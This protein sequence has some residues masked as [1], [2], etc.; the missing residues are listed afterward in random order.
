[1]ALKASGPMGKDWGCT[2]DE[3]DEG[4]TREGEG[5]EISGSLG[6]ATT[7]IAQRANAEVRKRNWSIGNRL[8]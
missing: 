1:M 7:Y 3:G 8:I 5:V 4:N 2:C 6:E